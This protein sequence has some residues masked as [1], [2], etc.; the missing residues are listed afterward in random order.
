MTRGAFYLSGFQMLPCLPNADPDRLARRAKLAQAREA[1]VFAHKYANPSLPDGVALAEKVPVSQEF[2]PGYLGKVAWVEAELL[3]N[4]VAVDFEK[5]TGGGSGRWNILDFLGITRLVGNRHL[6]FSR[7]LQAAGRV[8]RSFPVNLAAY[9]ALFGTI[10]KTEIVDLLDDGQR[11]QDRAFAWQRVAGANPV[12]L[13]G[14]RV[15]ADR[16]EYSPNRGQDDNWPPAA[17][18]GQLPATFHLDKTVFARAMKWWR[19]EH[20]TLEAA[21]AERRL[22]VC[23]YRHHEGLPNGTW[24]SGVLGVPR[25]KY[26]YAPIAAFVRLMD[27]PERIGELV[28][29]CIQ[30]EQGDETVFTPDQGV[31]WQMAKTVVQSADGTTQ[32]MISHLAYTHL[33][34]EAAIVAAFRQLAPNHPLL[35]LLV[36]HFEFTLA[37]NDHAVQSLIAPGGPVDEVFGSTL[38]GSLELTTRGLSEYDFMR[39]GA[40][41]DIKH[42]LVD[43]RQGLPDYPWR[44]D[45]SSLWPAIRRFVQRYVELY[46]SS[47]A[48]VADDRELAGFF[49]EFGSP[50]A[51]NIKGVV[52]VETREALIEAITTLI[53]TASAQHACLN[54]SQFPMMGYPPNVPGALYATKPTADTPE[55]ELNWLEMLPPAHKAAAQFTILYELSNVRWGK[56]GD[57]PPLHF[58]DRRVEPLLADFKRDLV[59]AE[60]EIVARDRY[61]ML[62]Y[63][64]LRP[65]QIGA[66]IYI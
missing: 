40:P 7:P 9:K 2:L 11:T 47:D 30:C 21:I 60:Q 22:Y 56:L 27:T 35:V 26:L 51:G 29:V 39:A 52:P 1:L 19:Q 14:I 20:D 6:I 12:M 46:Y 25:H 54:Y 38:V 64:Y 41:S 59:L 32:E 57:Y 36:P 62:S 44:D 18:P 31:R 17:P 34:M 61:R 3:A 66:S 42:R 16:S 63:P 24:D 28:P 48:D 8:A 55:N 4:H 43:D 15:S 65:S 45:A 37:L 33:V 5:L 10:S 53:W 58:L 50:D 49:R 13:K 23:D